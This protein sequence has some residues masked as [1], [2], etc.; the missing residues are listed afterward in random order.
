MSLM[1]EL[2]RYVQPGP[3]Y[4]DDRVSF[5]VDGSPVR[6]IAYYL[7]QFHSI[8][9]NDLWWGKG[10]TDWT[11]VT[12][13]FPR[14]R[15][16]YQP[17][18]P[19]ELGFYDLRDPEVLYRQA[20]LARRFG[21]VGFCIHH[22]WFGGKTLLG[23]P[24]RILLENRD[25]DIGFC[26]NWANENWTRTW[27]GS[28]KEILIAQNHS[29]EDDLRLAV[30]LEKALADP[31][32]IRIK[33]RP[34]VMIYRPGVLPDARATVERWRRHFDRAGYG[35]PYIVMPQAFGSLDPRVFGMDA[36]AGFP[37]HECGL[38]ASRRR[39]LLKLISPGYSGIV[40]SF[41]A[42]MKN[43]LANEPSD[44]TYFPGV[45]PSWDN[46][47]RRPKGGLVFEGSSP[48]KYG[49]WLR[50]AFEFALHHNEGDERIVFVNAWNEWAE[51]AHLEPDRYY[52]YAF[53]AQTARA[54][55]EIKPD[56]RRSEFEYARE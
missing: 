54:L 43:A 19:G 5:E 27:D 10:F 52:G 47:P 55:T 4:E 41:D 11:N 48:A 35:D 44:F 13:S 22:Y 50:A 1:S 24:L 20:N 18:L 14:F 38:R 8:P 26:I 46:H 39:H 40:R 36:A 21:L 33:G 31:R 32:Y 16:H 37:P 3:F 17:H 28:E 15:G 6:L 7:P 42:M 9:E 34:L 45:C 25:I 51:G 30:S 12:K 56:S 23:E 49:T 2:R 29:P 53:L